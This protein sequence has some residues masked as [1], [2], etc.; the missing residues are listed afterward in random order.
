MGYQEA[1]NAFVHDVYAGVTGQLPER[2]PVFA[3]GLR[4]N[5]VTSAVLESAVS[6]AWVDVA[7]MAVAR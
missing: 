1:F 3:D 7:E 6:A 5:R 4:M 2:V